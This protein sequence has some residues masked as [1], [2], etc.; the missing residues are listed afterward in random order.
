MHFAKFWRLA[1]RGA[2]LIWSE[3]HSH[4]QERNIKYNLMKYNLL[5]TCLKYV[6]YIY[7]VLHDGHIVSHAAISQPQ[8]AQ[9]CGHST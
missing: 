2:Q 1:G 3:V 7:A 8:V 4:V 5:H 9:A 6:D